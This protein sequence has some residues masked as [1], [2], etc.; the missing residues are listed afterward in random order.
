MLI[1]GIPSPGGNH[2]AGYLG[3]G[4][5]NHLYVTVGDGGCDYAGDSGCG[6]AND[7]SRDRNVLA[8]QGAAHHAR[9]AASRRT[10]RSGARTARAATRPAAARRGRSAR[11]PTPGACATRSGS[12]STPTPPAPASSSTTWARTRGRRSTTARP[13]P[14]TAGTCARGT[15]RPTRPPTAARPR[16]DDE[17]PLRLRRAA[18]AAGRS[19]AAPSCRTACG[20]PSTTTATCS[21]T[22][23]AAGS[24]AWRRPFSGW[25]PGAFG[26]DMGP[27]TDLTFGPWNSTQ[28]LYY[29][30]FEGR[31]GRIAYTGNRSPV[32]VA[33]A[34]PSSGGHAARRDLQRQRQPR[35]R[36]RH[37]ALRVE[38]RR[39]QRPGDDGQPGAR[40]HAGAAPTR[41]RCA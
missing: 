30:T 22:T 2:N 5:D 21:P 37:A 41:R 8:R 35:P 32:A 28:A 27:V 13:A 14:T 3:F 6:L 1:D 9:P 23:S 39:R 29:L 17:P 34:T 12:P 18:A 10:T 40:L 11:R 31:V 7:A 24:R 36:R 38:L 25:L 19:P 4:K 15:A 33:A 16:G 20:R 26:D